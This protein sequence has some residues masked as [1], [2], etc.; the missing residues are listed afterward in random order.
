M[1]IHTGKLFHL[2]YGRSCL[3]RAPWPLW[4]PGEVVVTIDRQHAICRN[5]RRYGDYKLLSV[6]TRA[7]GKET[8]R[9]PG[10]TLR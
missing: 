10:E 8:V 6:E 5:R 3:K 1:T 9:T 4:L 2:F 7:G